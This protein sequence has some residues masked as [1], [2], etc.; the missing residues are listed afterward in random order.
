MFE[1]GL[2]WMEMAVIA[3]LALM[4]IGPK[5]LPRVLRSMGHWMRK[6]RGLAHEFQSGLDDMVREADLE[7]A[8]NAIDKTR[9][10]NV[11][12]IIEDT[13]DPTGEVTE[14][15][16]DIAQT[17]REAPAKPKATD[18]K[19][20][21]E[22]KAKPGSKGAAADAENKPGESQP[23]ESAAGEAEQAKVI[24]HPAQVAPAHS[25]TPSSEPE[26]ETATGGDGKQKR[27]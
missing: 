12:K 23:N 3:L 5:E 22:P 1:I 7:D 9:N 16:R 14:E 27:A 17:S 10:L 4:V 18:P 25:L 11:N 15:A 20:E 6:I 19:P 2:G 13:V 21:T 26:I 8:K 24:N